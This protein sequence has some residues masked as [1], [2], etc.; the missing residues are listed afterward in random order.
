MASDLYEDMPLGVARIPSSPQYLVHFRSK[1]KGPAQTVA[2]D[3]VQYVDGSE[4]AYLALPTTDTIG[5]AV[6]LV[7]CLPRATP[8]CPGRETQEQRQEGGEGG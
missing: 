7:C 2:M 3:N 4:I 6:N 1:K 8:R 5:P